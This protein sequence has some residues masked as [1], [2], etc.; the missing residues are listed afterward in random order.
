MSEKYKVLIGPSAL[1]CNRGD[2]TLVWMAIEEIR[3]TWPDCQIAIMSNGYEDP[4]DNQSCQTKQLGIK[5]LPPLLPNPRRATGKSDDEIID[6]GF[7]LIKM[8]LRAILDF[9]Q[10]F[11]L[12]HLP[13]TKGIAR[14]FLGKQR[15][16]TYKYLKQ[17]KA[18][19]LKGGGYIYSY[20]GLKWQYYIWFG[21]FPIRMALKYGI[22]VIILPNSFGPFDSRFGKR[23]AKKVLRSCDFVASREKKS[24]ETISNLIQEKAK[25]YPDMGFALETDDIEWA[26][27]TLLEKGVPLGQKK[28]VGI[29]MRPWRFPNDADPGKKYKAYIKVFADLIKYL[30]DNDYAPVLFAHVIGPHAHEDDRIALK[31]VIG[32]LSE[33]GQFLYVDGDYNCKQIKAFYHF[34]DSMVCTRFH[35]AIFSIAQEIPCLAISYQGYKAIGIME[36][37]GLSEYTFDIGDLD[38]DSMISAFEKMQNNKQTIKTNMRTF[39][40]NVKVQMKEL[41]SLVSGILSQ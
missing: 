21:L 9:F 11:L 26:R 17:C 27:S 13:D 15:Y 34:M 24:Y 39:M 1:D 23:L 10:M 8:Q 12:L 18:F 19:V 2:Q 20:V 6:T 38:S 5:V 29:T 31:D 28:C 41:S 16:E 22:K 37:I 36:E 30:I 25:V 3:N 7:S 33:D 35:S 4:N 32:K 40:K 14:L